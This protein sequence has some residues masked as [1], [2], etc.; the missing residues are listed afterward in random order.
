MS[1]YRLPRYRDRTRKDWLIWAFTWRGRTWKD[2]FLFAGWLGTV[3]FATLYI[4]L[5]VVC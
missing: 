1:G 3:M 4:S 5:A 2:R